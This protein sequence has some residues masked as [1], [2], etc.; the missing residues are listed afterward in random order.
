MFFNYQ[1]KCESFVCELKII[2]GKVLSERSLSTAMANL[3]K[4][5]A[6]KNNEVQKK[7]KYTEE[8]QSAQHIC[9]LK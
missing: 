2:S 6:A 3:H 8:V 7:Q 5:E 4:S 9:I 1:I